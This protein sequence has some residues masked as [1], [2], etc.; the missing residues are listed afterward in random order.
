MAS[1]SGIV[2]WDS[3][4]RALRPYQRT[5]ALLLATGLTVAMLQKDPKRHGL[6][7]APS[8][9]TVSR[10]RDNPAFI[11]LM[12]SVQA[13]IAARVRDA[14]IAAIDECLAILARARAGELAMDDP[15]VL[16]AER[17]LARTVYPVYVAQAS[18]APR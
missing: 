11:E 9:A 13:E 1:D 7:R 5:V 16:H 10:W 4:H 15:L 6:K 3:S 18:Q 2:V 14:T 12:E 8:P 17:Q